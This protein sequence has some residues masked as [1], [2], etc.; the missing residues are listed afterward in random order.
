MAK[1]NHIDGYYIN[2]DKILYIEA[3]NSRNDG[4]KDSC[5]IHFANNQK[6]LY[7]EDRPADWVVNLLSGKS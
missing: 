4:P 7:L 1:F 2:A 6:P 5:K 3:T